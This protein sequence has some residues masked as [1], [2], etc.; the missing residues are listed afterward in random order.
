VNVDTEIDRHFPGQ[1]LAR[2][3]VATSNNAFRS[4]VS[5]PT[6]DPAQPL[7]FDALEQKFLRVTRG[8]ISDEEQRELIAGVRGLPSDNGALLLQ[9][10][11]S[12]GS[13]A[14]T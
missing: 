6:G 11:G 10:L 8:T 5:G 9:K 12:V 14:S 13:A 7:T 1:T 4:T 3:T 2:V